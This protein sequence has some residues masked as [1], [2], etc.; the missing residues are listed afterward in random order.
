MGQ[1]VILSKMMRPTAESLRDLS[2]DELITLLLQ[3]AE[4][5]ERLEAEVERLKHPP[6]TSR[7]SSQPPERD[8]K[9]NAPTSK[10]RRHRGARTGHPKSDRPMTDQPDQVIEVRPSEC[11]HCGYDL[12][13]LAP[14]R[15]AR[16]QITEL[17]E[18]KPVVIETRQH[19]VACPACGQTARGCCR[20]AWK[21]GGTLARGWKR[22]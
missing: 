17:P 7:N 10:R 9:A 8:Q 18:I 1:G 5:L 15:T 3:W 20:P 22:P 2:R 21:R 14:R 4:R 19:D 11:A 13:Q 16:R 6:T 12:Q